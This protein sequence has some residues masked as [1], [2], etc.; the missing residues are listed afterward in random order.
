MIKQ[1]YSLLFGLLSVV[2][3]AQIYTP[4]S[5]IQGSSN[6]QKVGIGTNQPQ[7]M[8]H[9]KSRDGLGMVLDVGVGGTQ[10]GGGFAETTYP[11]ELQYTNTTGTPLPGNPQPVNEVRLRMHKSGRLDVGS[12][13]DGFPVD[14]MSRLN[15]YRGISLFSNVDQ[16]LHFEENT[17]RWYDDGVGKFKIS[18]GST[19]AGVSGTELFSI[20]PNGVVAINT[21]NTAGNYQLYVGGGAIAEEV[22]VKLEG[23]WPDYVFDP[24]YDLLSL[25]ALEAYTAKHRHLPH[26]PSSNEVMEKGQELGSNQKALV[27]KVEEL[28]LHLIRLN[29]E[30]KAAQEEIELIK[31]HPTS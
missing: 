6:S 26:L 20:D 3:T 10:I 1:I 5:T 14:P 23:D 13:F 30:L 21:T 28:T 29:K 18:H 19:T 15:I 11:F 7:G 31:R 4:S 17:I 12:T 25:E 22:T 24:S 8:L 16:Y 2:A 9:V 27:Q